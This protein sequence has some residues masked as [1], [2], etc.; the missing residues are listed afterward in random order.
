M[1]E[2]HLFAKELKN[3]DMSKKA[4]EKKENIYLFQGV[5][6]NTPDL[7]NNVVLRRIHVAMAIHRRDCQI[8]KFRVWGSEYSLA[9]F[10]Q[11]AK[12]QRTANRAKVLSTSQA[13][14]R[15]STR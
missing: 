11:F 9:C 2:P 13:Q 1:P 12:E 15:K 4:A 5:K 7:D 10:I 14:S 3:S 8:G 6:K